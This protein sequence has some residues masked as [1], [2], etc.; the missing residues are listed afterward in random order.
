M[1]SNCG[2]GEDSWESLRHSIPKEINTKYSLEGLVLKLKLQYFGHLKWRVDSLEKTLMLGKI[3]GRRRR[4]M[5]WLDGII[6]SMDMTL[7]KLW[8]IVKDREVWCA[9]VHAVTKLDTTEQLKNS[10]NAVFISLMKDIGCALQPTTLEQLKTQQNCCP[11]PLVFCM[12]WGKSGKE[13]R[14]DSKET[15]RT[16]VGDFPGCSVV[17]TSSAEGVGSIPGLG[18]KIPHASQ[19]KNQNIKQKQYCKKSSIKTLKMVHIRKI[20]KDRGGV[21]RGTHSGIRKWKESQ[22]WGS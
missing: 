6:N 19:P 11:L 13:G 16:E 5:R 7:S 10:S 20:K 21:S 22:T 8:E 15:V 3:E 1:L 17:K 12:C 4:G 2:A 18:A 14:T 9:V